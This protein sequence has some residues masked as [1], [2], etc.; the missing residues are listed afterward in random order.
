MAVDLMPATSD[1][2][3]RLRHAVGGNFAIIHY[4][5]QIAL[6]L[7]IGASN[8]QRQCGKLIQ[9]QVQFGCRSNRKPSTRRSRTL[10]MRLRP[11]RRTPPEY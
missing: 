6:F 7:L 10:P 2:D 1:P 5:R 4:P 11:C 8:E 3:I 9:H